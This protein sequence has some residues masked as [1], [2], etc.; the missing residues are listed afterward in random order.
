MPNVDFGQIGANI[1]SA[2]GPIVGPVLAS[3]AGLMPAPTH[4]IHHVSGALAI[5]LIPLPYPGFQGDL[6]FIPDGAF[7]GATGGV[8]TDVNK[9]VGLAFTAVVG[10][11]L[12]LTYDGNMWY[13]GY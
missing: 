11:P 8:A 1:G 12:R 10:R 5:T 3:A 2:T 9:P 7:T 4:R 6:I 13:P